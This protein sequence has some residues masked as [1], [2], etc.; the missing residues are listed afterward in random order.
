MAFAIFF[1][2]FLVF[3]LPFLKC[4]FMSVTW[5]LCTNEERWTQTE[6]AICPFSDWYL[7]LKSSSSSLLFFISIIIAI[8]LDNTTFPCC[9]V[10]KC[11]ALLR[12][13]IKNQRRRRFACNSLERQ[14]VSNKNTHCQVMLWQVYVS[15][16]LI[17]HVSPAKECW[18]YRQGSHWTASFLLSVPNAPSQQQEKYKNRPQKQTEPAF[19]LFDTPWPMTGWP[20]PQIAFCWT[21]RVPY[22]PESGPLISKWKS[23]RAFF[24][25]FVQLFH[26]FFSFVVTWIDILFEKKQEPKA[27]LK[28]RPLFVLKIKP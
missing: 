27:N 21:H 14:L 18:I 17:A 8:P 28:R 7:Y 3:I 4:R 20:A 22:P 25:N 2:F 15:K 23:N 9:I 24:D 5:L 10:I 1:L 6:D 12:G 11:R 26:H 19:V 13:R 16:W